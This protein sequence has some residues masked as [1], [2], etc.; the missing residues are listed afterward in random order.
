MLGKTSNGMLASAKEL[1]IGDA[2]ERLLIIDKPA[3]PGDSFKDLYELDDQIIDIE[4]KMFTHR[5][6]CFGLLGVARELA[7]I[8]N[9]S[10]TTPDWYLKDQQPEPETDVIPLVVTNQLPEL[11]PRF[12]AVV[13]SNIEVAPSPVQLQSY[14]SRMG[15]R[16]INNIVDSTNFTMLL[17]G[18][19][20]HAYDYDKLKK[21]AGDKTPE[22]I[23]RHPKAN[24]NLELINSKKVTPKPET[25]LI[26]ANDI[27]VGIGGVMGSANSEV[28]ESTKNI[29]LEAASFDMYSIRR[30]SMELG[31][32]SEAVT[33]FSKGQ[34][35][36][37]SRKVLVSATKLIKDLASGSLIA[38]EIIDNN[39]LNDSVTKANS[40]YGPVTVSAE[41]INDRLGSNLSPESMKEILTNVEFEVELSGNELTV[42]A[43][44][45][46]TDIEIKEDIVEEVGRLY[47]YENI[48]PSPLIREVNSLKTNKLL[49][50]KSDLRRLLLRAGAN[51][52][53]TYT[54]VSKKILTN[55]NQDSTKAYEIANSLS[56]ELNNYRLSLSP[57]LLA[58]VHQNIK[59]GFNQ[60]VL[61][62]LGVRH[63]VDWIVE[64]TPS[65]L[66]S[67]A[68]VFASKSSPKNAPYFRARKYLDFLSQQYGLSTEL[69]FI[70]LDSKDLNLSIEITELAKPFEPSRSAVLLDNNG[71]QWGVVGEYLSSVK[72]SFKLPDNVAGFE[73]DPR[74][75][76]ELTPLN[77]YRTA[78]KYPTLKQD[79]TLGVDSLVSYGE[80]T[81]FIETSLNELKPKNSSYELKLLS[82]FNPA[83]TNQHNYSFRLSIVD[84]NQT[85][86]D[87]QVNKLLDDVAAKASDKLKAIRI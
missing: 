56:P 15:I 67:L 73:L 10:F 57:S 31:V 22:F 41:Y 43:P 75:F 81:S 45:W 39:N 18:Q 12:C 5:P 66:Q 70:P 48:S 51:E 7:G 46:R 63:Q 23:V 2:H 64:D 77:N 19:P 76:K 36:L 6:D 30:S 35:P 55:A 26:T 47:G 84:H 3:K 14:L 8:F 11:V 25:I 9:K 79:I 60:F 78:S 50:L 53:L 4:N 21:I 69:S 74:L 27:P 65:E 58:K 28:D 52:L 16:P 13:I 33:R 54:F 83:E 72:S 1:A 40:L 49:D 34:S 59:S 24:E 29:V 20:L 42:K 82:I 68:L 71:R 38:S 17:T 32:F 86:I 85:L 61:F 80:I 44:F 37:A 62:E 87:Q